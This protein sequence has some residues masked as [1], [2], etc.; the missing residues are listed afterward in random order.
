MFGDT[1]PVVTEVSFKE[2]T[3]LQ[4]GI[5]VQEL[6]DVGVTKGQSYGNTRILRRRTPVKWLKDQDEPDQ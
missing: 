5:T 2:G 4:A 6:Q 3:Q 1:T